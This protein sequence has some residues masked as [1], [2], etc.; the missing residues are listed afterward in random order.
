LAHFFGDLRPPIGREQ[1][2]ACFGPTNFWLST[3][4]CEPD[5]GTGKAIEGLFL[6]C[7]PNVM[8]G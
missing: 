6:E 7:G 8:E 3:P 2:V 4:G 5:P 1:A